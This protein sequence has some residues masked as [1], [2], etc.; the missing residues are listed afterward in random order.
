[1]NKKADAKLIDKQK[2][3]KIVDII[4]DNLEYSI[5]TMGHNDYDV[6]AFLEQRYEQRVIDD[7]NK[8]LEEE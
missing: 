7:I 5:E 1:M 6:T 3:D 8:I 4:V 2:L